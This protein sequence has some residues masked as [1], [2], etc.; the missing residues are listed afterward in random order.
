LQGYADMAEVQR[1]RDWKVVYMMK[2]VYGHT[3]PGF[4]RRRN[5][6]V[7]G[8]IRIFLSLFLLALVPLAFA[9]SLVAPH[10]AVRIVRAVSVAMRSE[11][12]QAQLTARLAI[13]V[14]AFVLFDCLIL[15]GL[16]IIGN[17]VTLAFAW[18]FPAVLAGA[19]EADAYLY[20]FGNMSVGQRRARLRMSDGQFG[21]QMKA[22]FKAAVVSLVQ[23]SLV[24]L[25]L[26]ALV[27]L[28][29]PVVL[30]V[31]RLPAMVRALRALSY[32]DL[33][34]TQKGFDA[35]FDEFKHALC[36]GASSLWILTNGAVGYL[37][38]TQLLFLYPFQTRSSRR[39]VF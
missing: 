2:S 39:Q 38:G 25:D 10:R 28:V 6:V 37:L 27:F 22:G 32:R 26:L 18:R 34:S 36:C 24:L 9:V 5:I 15:V 23:M 12:R 19:W 20:D 30:T 4:E 8:L 11:R 21:E 13:E 31:H 16:P 29:V 35:I 1:V 17:W 33:V 7:R 3:Q 14:L